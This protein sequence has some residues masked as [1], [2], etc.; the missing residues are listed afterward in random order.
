MKKSLLISAILLATA[1]STTSQNLAVIKVVFDGTTAS[2]S[3]P[4]TMTDVDYT[5]NGANVE[6]TSG[7]S[8]AASCRTT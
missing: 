1:I 6:I 2:V 8:T 5:V 7:T 4:S 3:M